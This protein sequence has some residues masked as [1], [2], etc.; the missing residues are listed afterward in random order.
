MTKWTLILRQKRKTRRLEQAA[1]FI[2][3]LGLLLLQT[4]R[5]I[6]VVKLSFVNANYPGSQQHRQVKLKSFRTM[7][8]TQKLKYFSFLHYI[9]PIFGSSEKKR[10]FKKLTYNPA[11]FSKLVPEK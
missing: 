10:S 1:G 4:M 11:T 5:A 6:A 8:S 2:V 9:Y 7:N 3:Q